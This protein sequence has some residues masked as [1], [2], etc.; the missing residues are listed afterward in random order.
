MQSRP[1]E[2]TELEKKKW[3]LRLWSLMLLTLVI[4]LAVSAVKDLPYRKA[5]R[6]YASQ[7][8]KYRS[9]VIRERKQRALCLAQSAEKSY[10]IK[11]K[12]AHL[13]NGESRLIRS[14]QDEAD[15]HEEAMRAYTRSVEWAV[16][17]RIA[18]ERRI[19]LPY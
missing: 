14:W 19:I 2:E 9:W 13:I 6:E 5:R 11:S 10:V 4:A 8:R 1:S 15:L 17:N 12:T 18:A 7:E 16:R 3:Q